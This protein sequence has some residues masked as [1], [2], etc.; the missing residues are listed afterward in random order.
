MG[1]A[2]GVEAF[3]MVEDRQCHVLVDEVDDEA[4]ARLRMAPHLPP[5]VGVESGW[6]PQDDLGDA[7][8]AD[9]VEQGAQVG[10]A[11]VVVGAAEVLGDGPGQMRG[12]ESMVGECRVA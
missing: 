2:A 1:V 9:V 6:L 11:G 8:L 12:P 10:V 7:Q 5:L 3:V 4:V